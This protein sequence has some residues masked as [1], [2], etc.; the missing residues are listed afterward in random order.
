M[1]KDCPSF[2]IITN[3]VRIDGELLELGQAS[4]EKYD[5]LVDFADFRK[6]NKLECVKRE[7]V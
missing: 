6:I 4:C 5:M 3:P 7:K 2:K 1:C